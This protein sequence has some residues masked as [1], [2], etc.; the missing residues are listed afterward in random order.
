MEFNEIINKERKFSL[1]LEKLFKDNDIKAERIDF[2]MDIEG[3]SW[4]VITCNHEFIYIDVNYN[5]ISEKLVRINILTSIRLPLRNN[6][7]FNNVVNYINDSDD[8]RNRIGCRNQIIERNL[9]AFRLGRMYVKDN[10]LYLNHNIIIDDSYFNPYDNIDSYH[11]VNI[12][13][14]M[15]DCIETSRDHII[16]VLPELY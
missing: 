16:A 8:S 3:F 5:I 13:N 14:D 2:G 12:I 15:V 6:Y 9:S 10:I 11:L 7:E 1:K 4:N